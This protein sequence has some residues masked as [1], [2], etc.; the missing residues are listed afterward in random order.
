MNPRA[1]GYK[2][3]VTAY[4]LVFL[5]LVDV[6]MVVAAFLDRRHDSGR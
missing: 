5:A 1:A 4:V 3:A 2:G 6:I